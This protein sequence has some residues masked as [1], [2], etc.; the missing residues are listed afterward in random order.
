MKRELIGQGAWR[1]R[2]LFFSG[3][4]PPGQ[5]IN[6]RGGVVNAQ[7][8]DFVWTCRTYRPCPARGP[9]PGRAVLFRA[10]P[11][12]SVPF[13]FATLRR[14]FQRRALRRI[15]L[16]THTAV[17][18]RFST[19]SPRPP[20]LPP[21]FLF[22]SHRTLTLPS[23]VPTVRTHVTYTISVVPKSFGDTYVDKHVCR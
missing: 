10:V 21:F 2:V 19:C 5:T 13:R 12:R 9:V 8:T 1:S 6:R 16:D 18:V 4:H 14:E 20:P 7:V 15:S 23:P 11:F 3:L 17:V 22:P